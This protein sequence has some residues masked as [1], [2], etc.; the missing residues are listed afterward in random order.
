[1]RGHGRAEVAGTVRMHREGPVAVLLLDHPPAQILSQRA[2]KGL[3]TALDRAEADPAIRAVIIGDAS[4]G[5]PGQVNPREFGAPLAAPVP[6][7][8][9]LRIES[10]PKPVV[11]LLA[12]N[13][14]GA[15][16]ELALAADARVAV[17]AARIGFADTLIGLPPSAGATQRLP[18]L[19]GAHHALTLMLTGRNYPVTS[20]VAQGI[21]DAIVPAA[22]AE[23]KAREIA[24]ALAEAPDRPRARDR[25]EGFADAGA[26]QAELARRRANAAPDDRMVAAVCRAVEAAQLFPFEA[27]LE[28]EREFFDEIA[29]SD[30]ARGL[31]HALIAETRVSAGIKA[32]PVAL[33]GILALGPGAPALVATLA[34]R[35]IGVVVHEPDRHRAARFA[36]ALRRALAA[37]ASLRAQTGAA[38]ERPED[39]VILQSDIAAMTTAELLLDLSPDDPAAKSA[40]LVALAALPESD[41]P[42]LSATRHLDTAAL[43]PQAA[44]GRVIGLHLPGRS[45][46]A[47]LAE[48]V[49]TPGTTSRAHGRARRFMQ[50]IR[51]IPVRVSAADGLAGPAMMG[52]LLAAADALVRVGLDPGE[53]DAAM[54]GYGFARGPYAMLGEI[55]AMAHAEREARLGRAAG[56]SSLIARAGLKPGRDRCSGA[57]QALVAEARAGRPAE[58]AHGWRASEVRTALLAALVNEG[59]RLLADRVVARPLVLDVVMVQGYGFPRTQGGPMQAAETIGLGHLSQAMRVLAELD[60]AVWAPHPLIGDLMA[61]GVGFSDLNG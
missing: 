27:G 34:Q 35:G 11:A 2:R 21:F 17:P 6:A 54:T 8:L 36:A 59:A 16:A 42:V 38:G 26:Y 52:A 7:A 45:F 30:R 15:G 14:T 9:A 40:A 56:L 48:L 13:V 33:A 37:R 31:R 55:A 44:R 23:A 12:G 32:P 24:L 29:A 60:K 46:P 5:F 4:G 39:R 50:Q 22:K 43:A 47:H 1:M 25:T 28:L 19:I 3:M 57:L 61:N 20:E 10:F 53:I 49:V 58:H 18:R 41:A 51:R